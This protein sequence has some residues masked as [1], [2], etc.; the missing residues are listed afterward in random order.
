MF[1]GLIEDV[2]KIGVLRI[3]KNSAVL[4]VKTKLPLRAMPLG[5][6]VAVNGACLTVVKK[7]KNVFMVDVS[8]ETLQ[9]TNL[10]SLA[11]GGLVN[12]EQPMR[13]QDRFGGHLV[14]GHVDGIGTI[15]AIKPEGGFTVFRFRVPAIISSLL[16]AK[17]SVAVDGISL[18]VNDCRRDGFS[19]AIIPFTLQHTNL[20]VRKV[21]DKV[22]LE[23]DLIGKYIQSFLAQRK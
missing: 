1:T 2:G 10:Q 16:V 8:P 15:T 13:F 12:L 22:N 6:S 14:T 17:G 9:R 5:A 11:A 23:T 20:R 21:G 7:T 19:V 4:E 18:T 3:A